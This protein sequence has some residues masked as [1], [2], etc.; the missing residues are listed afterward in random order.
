MPAVA[1]AHALLIRSN[2]PADALLS[3]SPSRIEMWFTEDLS[4][5]ASKAIVWDRYRHVFNE[6]TGRIAPHDSRELIVPVRHLHPGTYLVLWTSVSAVDGHV[7]RGSF[8]FSVKVR[9]P[10]PSLAGVSTGTGQTFPDA[11]TLLA[12]LAH[13]IELLAA[14]SWAGAVALFL[15]VLTPIAGA[16]DGPS[17]GAGRRARRLI[18]GTIAALIIASTVMLA[19][20]AFQIGGGWAGI[21]A[22]STLTSLFQEQYGRL[23]AARQVVALVGLL[24]A[25]LWTVRSERT[26]PLVPAAS[27]VV[28]AAYLYLLAASGHLA[29]AN[30]GPAPDPYSRLVSAGILD[31]WAHLIADALWLGGQVAIAVALVPLLFLPGASLGPAR[32]LRALDR[33]SPLAYAS[34]ATYMISGFVTAKVQ[35]PSWYAYF[36]SI[37]GRA[38]IIKMLLIGLMMLISVVTVFVLRPRLKRAIQSGR[39]EGWRTANGSRLLRLLRV[40]PVL[41]VGVLLATSVMFYY[42]V[43]LGFAPPGPAAYVAHTAG[44]TASLRIAPDRSGP[45][46]LYVTLRNAQGAPVSRAHVVVLTTMLDM[47][48]GTGVASLKETAPGSFSGLTDLG[49]GGHWRLQI[50]IYTPNGLSRTSVDVLVGA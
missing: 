13:W 3:R 34:V 24:L 50:L 28:A 9:G 12:L 19:T 47:V 40:N 44:M 43:P 27:L 18:I 2:P 15:F 36:N 46:T 22:P 11:T 39:F 5:G 31:D 6:G 35:I 25:L 4:P 42:P 21:L 37:Y 14:V 7:L 48:M 38:L 33:F 32:F 16:G 8:V 17:A 26:R 1:L 30:V 45:N 23:W 29:A 41:G 10:G 20:Q 49:M